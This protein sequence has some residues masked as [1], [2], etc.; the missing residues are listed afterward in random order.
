MTIIA[1]RF[2]LNNITPYRRGTRRRHQRAA[3]IVQRQL[4]SHK[5]KFSLALVGLFALVAVTTAYSSGYSSGYSS[6]TAHTTIKQTITATYTE[7]AAQYNALTGAGNA[8]AM[9]ECAYGKALGIA[10]AASSGCTFSAGCTVSSS[11]VAGRR[12]NT[13]AVT[14]SA[15]VSASLSASATSS[16][17]SITSS[18]FSTALR[19]VQQAVTA[20]ASLSVPYVSAVAAP[21]VTTVSGAAALS[22]GI[23]ALAV[24]ALAVVQLRQ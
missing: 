9:S 22:T 21:T 1:N 5:M 17:S 12:S 4:N 2:F 23:V 19:D 16:S 6:S 15:G 13:L 14:Y 20:F 11:A 24:S 18:S 3:L 8:K 10:T 7:T